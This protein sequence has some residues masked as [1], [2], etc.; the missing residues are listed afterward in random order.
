MAPQTRSALTLLRG[1]RNLVT[2]I[3]AFLSVADFS[4]VVKFEKIS[5]LEEGVVVYEIELG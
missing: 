2:G 1:H 5:S 4:V 3:I